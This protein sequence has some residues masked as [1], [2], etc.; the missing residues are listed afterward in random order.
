MWGERPELWYDTP[1]AGYATV[2]YESGLQR[3]WLVTLSPWP[4]PGLVSRKFKRTALIR[5]NTVTSYE[6]YAANA[7]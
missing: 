3:T 7:T 2:R 6:R 1:L 4:M 5:D